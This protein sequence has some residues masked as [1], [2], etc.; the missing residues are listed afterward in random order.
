MT[1]ISAM[2]LANGINNLAI[3]LYCIVFDNFCIVKLI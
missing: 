1:S 3:N 2:N